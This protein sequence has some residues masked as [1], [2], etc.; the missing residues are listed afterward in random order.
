MTGSFSGGVFTISGTPGIAGTY[1]YTVTTSGSC[2]QTT[3]SGTITVM[4]S[5]TITLTSAPGTDTQTVCNATPIADIDYFIGGSGTGAFATGLPAGV[6]GTYSGGTF[7]IS[8]TPTLAGTFNYTVTTTGG[9]CP[10]VTASGT[11]TSSV[12]T[13]T[14]ISAPFTNDQSICFGNTPQ[15]IDYAVGGSG[16]G[17]SVSGLPAGM[18]GNTISSFGGTIFSLSGT[19]TETGTFYY[20]VTT[21]GSCTS[22]FAI[23]SIY[24]NPT[25]TGNTSGSDITICQNTS[26]TLA[27]GT[28][29]GGDGSYTYQWESST[30]ATGPFVPAPG[31][32]TAANYTTPPMTGTPPAT[33]FRRIVASGGCSD[34][35]APVMVAVD[36][37][38]VAAAGGSAVT[39]VDGTVT[40]TGASA[41]AGTIAWT[42]DGQGMLLN[43]ATVS[44]TYLPSLSDE[45]NT[46]TLTMTVTSSNSCGMAS[47]TAQ[48]TIAVTPI[49]VATAGGMTTICANGGTATVPGA[50]AANGTFA[51]S[52]NGQGTLTNAST[53]FPTYTAVPADAGD[54]ILLN[55]IVSGA[56]GCTYADTATYTIIVN[57]VGSAFVAA[58]SDA[59][60]S[61][62]SSA[63]LDA[64]GPAIIDWSWFPATGLSNPNIPDPVASPLV[65]TTYALTATD[66]NGCMAIDS[67]TITVEEDFNL[68]IAN[69][70]SPNGDTKNDTWIIMNIENYPN[71]AVMIVN[72]EGQFVYESDDYDNSWGGTYNGKLL[73]DGTYYYI[74]TFE[75]SDKVY[76]G[77][78]NILQN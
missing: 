47:D 46:V 78:V 4:P 65:T 5:A 24:I 35:A 43:G 25:I 28:V 73:P 44:P 14:L 72:R 55:L 26:T 62:G 13:L 34:T 67:V 39:C 22:S 69:I 23:G 59:T 11:I 41:G 19:P 2:L 76:K 1:N 27:G 56:G 15:N 12:Q 7:T 17:A 57:P 63:E 3:A 9:T 77:A 50:S 68:V 30:T 21:N 16:T 54:T 8:G 53:L 29:T 75:Q 6:T 36:S 48:F 61:L 58:G 74:V 52:H 49:P 51:W 64:V 45:G 70:V 71:T 31:I 38:P 60:I 37:L 32:N 66:V 10:A 42:H 18:T 20:T 40:V 33:W